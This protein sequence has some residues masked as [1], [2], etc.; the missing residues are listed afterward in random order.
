MPMLVL[1][2]PKL[3]LG[4]GLRRPKKLV[5]AAEYLPLKRLGTVRKV[6]MN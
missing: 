4:V 6:T 3:F 2:A 5:G 1:V